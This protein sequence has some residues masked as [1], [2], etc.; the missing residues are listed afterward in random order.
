MPE[1]GDSVLRGQNSITQRKRALCVLN[2][3]VQIL[4]RHNTKLEEPIC[5]KNDLD[6][7]TNDRPNEGATMEM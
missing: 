4:E 6:S 5:K 1:L 2:L 3:Y 7:D